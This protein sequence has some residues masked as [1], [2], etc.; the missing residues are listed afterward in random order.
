MKN[1]FL[2]VLIFT[3]SGT[4][5]V[6]QNK[7]SDE[8]EKKAQ[9]EAEMQHKK[10]MLEEEHRQM[11]QKQQQMEEQERKM[12]EL[13]WQYRDQ[14]RD[15]ERASRESYMSRSSGRTWVQPDVFHFEEY[16]SQASQTQLTLR[17]SF[18][19][20]SDNSDGEFQVDEGSRHFR[21]TINGKVKAGE[22]TIKITYPS[23]K[24][25]KD[26]TINSAAEITFS[27]ALTISEEKGDKYIGTWGYE[28][29]VDKAE[30][31]YMLSIMA[32]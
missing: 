7:K 12:R 26:L 2:L 25:F 6:A 5:I 30:G 14:A 17:N 18:Q 9:V 23:G 29:K 4:S 32:N 24:V 13:E 16:Q 21:C 15:M 10:Q 20:G 28:V 3:L 19:G 11:K 8:E 22:I 27:Q 31:S 1:F